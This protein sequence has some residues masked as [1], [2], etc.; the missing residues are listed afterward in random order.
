[1][2]SNPELV[3][4]KFYAWIFVKNLEVNLVVSS[5]TNLWAYLRFEKM[6]TNNGLVR[7][8]LETNHN[9]NFKDS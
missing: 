6:E 9:F 3:F 2:Q 8:N 1:M 7:Y 4:K 5:K